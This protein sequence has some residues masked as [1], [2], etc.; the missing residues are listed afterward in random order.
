MQRKSKRLIALAIAVIFLFS[1]TLPAFA[2]TTGYVAQQNGVYYE[3]DLGA[4]LNSYEYFQ[5]DPDSPQAALYKHFAA[6]QTVAEIDSEKGYLDF[7]ALADAYD[8]GNL[9][10][11]KAG[12]PATM[13]GETLISEVTAGEDGNIAVGDPKP[14]TPPAQELKVESVSAINGTITVTMTGEGTPVKSDFSFGYKINGVGSKPFP[15]VP[16]L[17]DPEWNAATKTATFTFTPFAPTNEAQSI[18]ICWKYEGN[19]KGGWADPFVVEAKVLTVSSVSAINATTVQVELAEAPA[20]DPAA[21][22]FAVKVD[23]TAVAVSAVAKAPN[24]TK[25]YNLTIASLNN[26]EGS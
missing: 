2:A 16:D 17:S 11:Y 25:T 22:D 14:I 20:T 6:G 7:N 9:D 15:D 12:T 24:T 19:E 4:L 10:E 13:P 8:A 23:G 18:E 5:V 26:K 1:M 21:G 3:Y